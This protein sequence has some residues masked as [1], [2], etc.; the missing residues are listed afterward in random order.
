MTSPKPATELSSRALLKALI[1]L[2]ILLLPGAGLCDP[3]PSRRKPAPREAALILYDSSGPD[4]WIG[5]LHA[6][7]LANLLGHFQLSYSIEPVEDYRRGSIGDSRA[8]FYVGS[9][10]DNPLPRAFLQDAMAAEGPVCWFKYNLWQLGRDTAFGSEFETRTGFRFEFM[11]SSGYELINYKGE[12]FTKNQLDAELGVATIL[13]SDLAAAPALACQQATT[14]CIPYIV[15]GGNF[16]YVADAPFAYLDEEDRYLVFADLLHDILRIP[17]P[18]SHRAVIRLE[19][20]DPTYPTDLLERAADYLHA[21]GVPFLVS[22]IPVYVD[23]L[24]FYND[25]VPQTVALTRAP[26]FVHALEYMESQGGQI[27]LHGY[28]HQYDRVPNPYTGV[29]GDDY[30]F[31]RVT[32][33]AQNAFVDYLPVPQ[34]SKHWAKSR[35]HDALDQLKRTGLSAIAWETPHY[36]A[37]PLDYEVFADRFPLTIQRVLYFDSAGHMAGRNGKRRSM[38]DS[39][40]HNAGQFFPYVIHRDLYGQKIVPENIGNIGLVPFGGSPMRLPSDLIR[41]AKKNLAVRDGWASGFFHPFLDLSY[42]QELVRGVK[43]LGYD[44]VPLS[45]DLQ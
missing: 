21:E 38:F 31:F 41:A 12:T 25:G 5:G 2:L 22:V 4:G 35:I 7:M 17:H 1:A 45:D 11:D 28:T 30:E 13:D 44:Y 34:D 37:S 19:D 15:H 10:F 6:R 23:P 36:A 9:V 32:V 20:I 8:T 43:A 26:E 14:N 3:R 39:G 27:V 16:W 40:G 29:S 42:L 24:G 18:E 33:D